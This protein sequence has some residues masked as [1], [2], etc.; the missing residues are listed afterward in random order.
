MNAC[1]K[2]DRMWLLIAVFPAISALFAFSKRS[3]VEWALLFS[4]T[5]AHADDVVLDCGDVWANANLPHE[6]SGGAFPCIEYRPSSATSILGPGSTYRLFYPA[7][8]SRYPRPESTAFLET[9]AQGLTDSVQRLGALLP[10]YPVYVVISEH[11]ATEFGVEEWDTLAT[12]ASTWVD[13][14][15][16]CPVVLHPLLFSKPSGDIKQIVAHEFFHCL[17]GAHFGD[18]MDEN[19]DVYSWWVE[20]TAEY[21]SSVVYPRNNAEHEFARDYTPDIEI[22]DQDYENVVFFQYLAD[23]GGLGDGG[24]IRFIRHMPVSE[25][26]DTERLALASFPGIQ[27]HFHGFGQERFRG[28]CVLS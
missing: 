9:V 25:T 19:Y 28:R 23:Q 10:A 18:R 16:P 21:F 12:A 4:I 15:E 6:R 22:L 3:S 1:N 20:G 5:S 24:I 2:Y 26:L 17:Q 13:A 14:D 27:D 7:I 11:F 8:W